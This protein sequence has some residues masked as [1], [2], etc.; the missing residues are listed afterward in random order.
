ME[1]QH[2]LSATAPSE[3]PDPPVNRIRDRAELLERSLYSASSSSADSVDAQLENIR[4]R[5]EQMKKNLSYG[6]E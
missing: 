3:C 4:Q 5:L 2:S 6:L 1:L